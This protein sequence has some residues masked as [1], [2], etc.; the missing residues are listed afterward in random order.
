MVEAS[1]TLLALLLSATGIAFIHTFAPDHWMPFAALGRAQGWSRWKLSRVTFAASLGHVGS[2]VIIGALGLWLGWALDA[3]Q[4]MQ[5]TRGDLAL[6]LLVAFG[7]GYAGWGMVRARK[8]RETHVHHDGTVH[9][10][11]EGLAQHQ[12]HAHSHGHHHPPAA[13]RREV[14][15]AK[16]TTWAMFVILVLGPCEAL[17]PL[18]FAGTRLGLGAVAWVTIAFCLST[19]ATMVGLALLAHA[20]FA[21]VRL[22]TLERHIHTLTGAAISATAVMVLALGI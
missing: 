11:G 13:A 8:W 16:V 14:A 12:H 18:M 5:G 4:F 1:P 22:Q 19:M 9:T 7:A 2:S 15:P 10:H 21:L 20:G 3:I 17:V 6:Y